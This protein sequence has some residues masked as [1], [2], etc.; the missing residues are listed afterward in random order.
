MRPRQAVSVRARI[1]L[2]S[3]VVA[4]VVLVLASLALVSVLDGQL[5]RQGDSS[6]RARATELLDAAATGALQP[7]VAPVTDDGMVQVLDADGH[8][9]AASPNLRTAAA[10]VP[11]ATEPHGAVVST[12]DA[13][14]DSETEHYRI[15]TEARSTPDGLVTA[16]VGTSL[17]SGSE[18][19]RTLRASLLVGVPLML[20]LLALGV[21]LLVGR[22]LA[23]V[24][25]VRREVDAIGQ[26]DLSQRLDPGPPDEVGRLV[27]TLNGMLSRLE[28]SSRRERD[29]VA[30]ASHELQSPLTA[31]RTQLEVARAQP[32]DTDWPRLRD[33]LLEDTSRMERLVHDL[34]L[35]AAGEGAPRDDRP[36]DLADV[37]AEEV[38]R[39]ADGD[40]RIRL[41]VDGPAPVRGDVD[42]LARVVRNLLDNAREHA[43]SSIYLHVTGGSETCTVTV[44]DD[45][46]GVRPEDR[47][48][49]FER[50][51]RSDPARDRARAG[52]GLGLPIAR[53][54]ARR[55]GGELTLAAGG[56]GA[57]FVLTLP[58]G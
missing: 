44:T 38:A 2:L 51:H 39:V 13:P 35:L 7:V 20:V 37:A 12:L 56:P 53:S 34:L 4:A 6:A 43:A 3:T 5:T 16:V 55:H 14:D 11:A 26:Q 42:Q 48:R 10:V 54:L 57:T 45:G 21:W 50:F 41:V 40:S 49:V 30:D 23:R 46:P 18:A 17:E 36:L 29:F 27:T 8:V 22:S 25:R 19:T 9:L 32:T 33:D 28:D 47:E 1:T 31:F 58:R 15:W 52:T 24:E